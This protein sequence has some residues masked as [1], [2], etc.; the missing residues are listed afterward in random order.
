VRK[1]VFSRIVLQMQGG[2]GNQL[3]QLALGLS[4][5][6]ESKAKLLVDRF[7]YLR[8]D[9]RKY[10]LAFLE[11][12]FNFKSTFLGRILF[13]PF[14]LVKESIEFGE[15][16]VPSSS[17]RIIRIR[18]YFQNPTLAVDSIRKIASHLNHLAFMNPKG[19]C[20][21]S[22]N[23]VGVHVRRGDYLSIEANLTNFGV[24]SNDYYLQAMGRFDADCTHFIIFSEGQKEL[25]K[26]LP[27]T[28]CI[29]W[30]DNQLDPVHLLQKMIQNESFV[31]S[32][33]SLSWWA[34]TC[35]QQKN[36]NAMIVCPNVWFRGDSR[37]N[38]MINKN[39]ATQSAKWLETSG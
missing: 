1:R 38:V 5:A 10:E 8:P 32:N 27:K 33:S 14:K 19:F 28:S 30:D 3:F 23:H 16:S 6:R 22:R 36:P 35:I 11:E 20:T 7:S 21:C 31:M 34:A 29:S 17:G 24:L 4:L 15:Y 39:W 2:L 25:I 18:G 26:E 12:T 9:M 13:R 37:S